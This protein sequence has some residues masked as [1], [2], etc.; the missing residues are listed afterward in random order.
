M[1]FSGI[2]FIYSFFSCMDVWKFIVEGIGISEVIVGFEVEVL[3]MMKNLKGEVVY[4]EFDFI[5]M[6]FKIF[7]C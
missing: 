1:E 6:E 2:G 7:D 3:V 5:I 4:E